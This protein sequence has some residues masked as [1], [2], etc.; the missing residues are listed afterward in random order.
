MFSNRDSGL[1]HGQAAV[2][3]SSLASSWEY[4]MRSRHKGWIVPDEEITPLLQ[5]IEAKIASS[6]INLQHRDT[7][8][9]LRS[10]LEEDLSEAKH[11][12]LIADQEHR[13][14]HISPK[15]KPRQPIQLWTTETV[16]VIVSSAE[17][18]RAAPPQ[19]L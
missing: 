5:Q 10:M 14:G 19:H 11:R 9:R 2:S 15:N 1:L 18:L 12:L 7:L 8:L 16:S 4:N 3:I 17:L 13:S 6:E